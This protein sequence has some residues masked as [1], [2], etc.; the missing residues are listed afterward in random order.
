[1]F[2]VES[3]ASLFR[4]F[5]LLDKESREHLK[6]FCAGKLLLVCQLERIKLHFRKL[7]FVTSLNR[8]ESR[9]SMKKKTGLIPEKTLLELF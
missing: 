3:H 6:D 5:Q 9:E 2:L 8:F 7:F 4:S 1:M